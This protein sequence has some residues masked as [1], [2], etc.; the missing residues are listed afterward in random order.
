MLHLSGAMYK[1]EWLWFSSPLFRA[2]TSL[3]LHRHMKMSRSPPRSLPKTT[4]FRASLIRRF[5]SSSTTFTRLTDLHSFSS[6]SSRARP[7]QPKDCKKN[8]LENRSFR[9]CFAL[10]WPDDLAT[11][12]HTTTS[13]SC[14]LPGKAY[15]LTLANVG[16]VFFAEHAS[17][18]TVRAASR[19]THKLE[20]RVSALPGSRIDTQNFFEIRF[21]FL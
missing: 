8:I 4:I 7:C 5:H 20:T 11:H 13:A 17:G 2:A 9:S 14:L 18:N 15:E 6:T 3:S 16:R 19:N 21:D 1:H 12:T 10:F